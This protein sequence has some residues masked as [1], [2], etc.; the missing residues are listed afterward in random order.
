MM[1]HKQ[2]RETKRRVFQIPCEM[3]LGSDLMRKRETSENEAIVSE[4]G[5]TV[6]QKEIA[7]RA[8]ISGFQQTTAHSTLQCTNIPPF[9]LP[10]KRSAISPKT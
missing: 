8:P 9:R 10:A 7:I 6:Q 2:E 3:Q 1:G 5:A 4:F